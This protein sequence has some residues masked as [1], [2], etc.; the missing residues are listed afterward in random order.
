MMIADKR[1]VVASGA[2][3]PGALFFAQRRSGGNGVDMGRRGGS[4]GVNPGVNSGSSIDLK[5][6]Q[7]LLP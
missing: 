5:V 2:Y 3:N 7:E 6:L 4:H 1:C